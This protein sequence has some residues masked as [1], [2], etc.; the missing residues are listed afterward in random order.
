MSKVSQL[1]L[2]EAADMAA[3][4]ELYIVDVSEV[5]PANQSKRTTLEELSEYFN[6][7]SADPVFDSVTVN[8]AIT[9]TQARTFS[10]TDYFFWEL[11]G[12]VPGNAAI[13][14]RYDATGDTPVLLLFDTSIEILPTGL[15]A[16]GTSVTIQGTATNIELILGF[17]GSGSSFLHDTDANEFIITTGL[18]RMRIASNT[19]IQMDMLE[20]YDGSDWYTLE[21]GANDS[22]GAGFRLLRIPNS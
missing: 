20:L 4:D 10:D 9:A 15:N 1:D 14:L 3:L 18:N 21:V 12:T 17:G 11:F 7:G 5:L 16:P 19:R 13:G 6:A 22:G 8:T 2:L